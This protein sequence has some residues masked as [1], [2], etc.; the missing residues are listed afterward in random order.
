MNCQ[1][2][3]ILSIQKESRSGLC[4]GSGL[5]SLYGC[6]DLIQEL[7]AFSS[8][9]L[10]LQGECVIV[11]GLGSFQ[12]EQHFKMCGSERQNLSDPRQ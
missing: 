4:S 9:L 6:S 10:I 12:V 11:K 7:Q 3:W 5:R 8:P 2:A 1:F